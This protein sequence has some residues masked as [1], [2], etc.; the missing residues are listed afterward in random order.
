MASLPAALL[1]DSFGFAVAASGF[2]VEEG[3]LR[4]RPRHRYSPLR[5]ASRAKQLISLLELSFWGLL[6]FDKSCSAENC[7]FAKVLTQL[8]RVQ[9]SLDH[10]RACLQLWHR[11]LSQYLSTVLSSSSLSCASL[12]GFQIAFRLQA[13]RTKDRVGLV[14]AK[15]PRAVS[16]GECTLAY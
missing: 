2:G 6:A 15:L 11:N 4:L 12:L 13:A 7:S 10:L 5:R 3:C 8:T 14:P 16:C 9:S 1:F